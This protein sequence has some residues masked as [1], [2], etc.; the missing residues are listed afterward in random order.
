MAMPSAMTAAASAKLALIHVSTA[1]I[2]PAKRN[3]TS[4]AAPTHNAALAVDAAANAP[5]GILSA[6]AMGGATVEKP[7]TN[8]DSTTEKKPQRSKMPSVCRTH[9]SGDSDTRQRKRSTG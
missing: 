4:M 1:S 2:S 5:T 6:P 7:G 3:P 8:F 9:V